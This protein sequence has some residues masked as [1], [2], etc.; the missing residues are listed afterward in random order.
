MLLKFKYVS[1]SRVKIIIVLI[2]ILGFSI[3]NTSKKMI[4]INSNF[5]YFQNKTP[6]KIILITQFFKSPNPKRRKE[7]Q[8]AVEQNINNS[9]LDKIIL[10][11]EKIYSN[12]ES[13]I[14]LEEIDKI[15]QINHGKRLTFQDSFNLIKKL[16][17]KS[18]TSNFYLLSNLDIFFDETL[19]NLKKIKL[20]CRKYM[21]ALVRN[22][23]KPGMK[24]KDC[25]TTGVNWAQ[26]TWIIHSN[27]LKHLTPERLKMLDFRMGVGRCDN[28]LAFLLKE[29]GLQP[30][31]IPN[32]IRSYHIH[33]EVEQKKGW[34]YQKQVPGRGL[35]LDPDYSTVE[36]YK[37]PK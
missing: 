32:V 37:I 6:D 9:Y 23:F 4:L 16:D 34:K 15:E 10:P 3:L 13:G 12:S 11:N 27:N 17:A 36:N 30:Q 2:L 19:R 5:E 31:S 28:R 7:F 1:V 18:K 33:D 24:L 26:D 25:K 8:Y 22:E 14:N 35:F 20:D 29:W 21:L